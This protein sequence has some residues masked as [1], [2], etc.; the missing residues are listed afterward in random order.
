MMVPTVQKVSASVLRVSKPAKMGDGHSAMDKFYPPLR[1]AMVSI[2]IVM[3]PLT[4]T[5]DV[6]K[7]A[8]MAKPAT[9][10]PALRE[11]KM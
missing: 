10:I 8:K 5:P 9:A 4:M 11:L 7:I 2:T 6:A 1:F 3:A